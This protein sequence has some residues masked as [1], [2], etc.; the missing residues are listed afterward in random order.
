MIAG[1]GPLLTVRGLCAGYGSVRVLKEVSLHVNQGE[2]VAVLGANG[3]GKTTTLRTIC[4]LL[5]ATSGTVVFDGQD[6]TRIPAHRIVEKGLTMV[7]EGRQ[8]FGPF[9]AYENL[10]MGALTLMRRGKKSEVKERLEQVYS[11]FPRLYERREQVAETLSGGEQQMLAIGRALMAQPRLLLLDEPSIGLGPLVIEAI[12]EALVSLNREGVTILLVE[13]NAEAALGAAGR[14]YVMQVGTIA[15]EG[16]AS[17]I[18]D[19]EEL[20]LIYLGRHR[21]DPGAAPAGA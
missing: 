11:L 4:G 13:Q 21:P 10:E 2:M 15:M 5:S 19:S 3:A 1:D 9:T 8:I 16:P 17:A 6:V 18:L 12:F 7:P 14:A 20:R